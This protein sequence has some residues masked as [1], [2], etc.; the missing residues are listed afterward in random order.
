MTHTLRTALKAKLADKQRRDGKR[1]V[2]DADRRRWEL[3]AT[4]WE[5]WQMPFDAD[6]DWPVALRDALLAYRR[7]WRAKMDEVNAAIA[8]NAEQEALVDQP[9]VVPGVVRVSGPFTVEGVMPA[10]LSLDDEEPGPVDGPEGEL[11]TFAMPNGDTADAEAYL[12]RMIRYLRQDGVRFPDNKV[13]AVSRLDPLPGDA[14]LHA[15]GEWNAAN[16]SEHRLAVS[17]GPEHGPV[18]GVQVEEA[19]RT[20]YRRGYDDLVFAGFSFD[21][22]AQTLVQDDPNPRVRVHLA[23]IRPD[24][25][26]GGLLKETPSAQLFTVFG[27]PRTELR[28]GDDGTYTVE[29]QGVDVYDPVQNVLQPTRADKVAAWFLDSDYDGQTF[30]V[31]QAFFPDRSAWDKLARAL[32]GR[33]DDGAWDAF[34]GTVSLPF[35]AGEHRRVAVKVVDPR[36]NEVMRVHRLPA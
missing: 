24:V 36:G 5:E 28:E 10:A 30:C 26:M 1:A 31:A 15:E 33:V 32:K 2:T 7:A 12:D 25:Q 14:W 17:F 21:D 13:A 35:A 23:Y 20:A 19:L 3:P 8:A 9:E 22:A 11:D 34:A 29:M 18:T 4:K 6:D 27:A 16:G